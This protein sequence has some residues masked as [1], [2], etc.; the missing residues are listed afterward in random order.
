MK[1]Q[2]VE[3]LTQEMQVY[4][5]SFWAKKFAEVI[6]IPDRTSNNVGGKT[7]CGSS[8]ALL[9]NNYAPYKVKEGK[10]LC[11]TCAKLFLNSLKQK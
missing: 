1:K 2:T 4:P 9:G 10:P 11:P 8:A 3:T 7:Y 5:N 6:C